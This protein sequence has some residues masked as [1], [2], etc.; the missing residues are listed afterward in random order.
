M[1]IASDGSVEH[2]YGCVLQSSRLHLLLLGSAEEPPNPLIS[3]RKPTFGTPKSN[4]SGRFAAFLKAKMRCAQLKGAEK[5]PVFFP[6]KTNVNAPWPA[7]F[8]TA[9]PLLIIVNH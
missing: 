5:R 2:F 8:P 9:F 4:F 6:K 1:Q 3:L 7:L